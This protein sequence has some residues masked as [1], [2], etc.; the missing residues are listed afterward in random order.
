MPAPPRFVAPMQTR[1]PAAGRAPGKP[2]L[3]A[4]SNADVH[5]M[6]PPVQYCRRW[7]PCCLVALVTASAFGQDQPA[8]E[9]TVGMEGLYYLRTRGPALVARPVD[10]KAPVVLRI[11]DVAQD[12]GSAIYELRYAGMVPGVHDL[13]D[14]LERV[15][16]Q[17]LT[18]LEPILVAVHKALPDN[19]DG[20]LV[21]LAVPG[22]ARAWMYRLGLAAVGVLWL[23]PMAWIVVKRLA[24]RRSAPKPMRAA[25]ET[26]ADQLQPLIEAAVAGQLT[27]EDQARLELLLIAYWRE[28][29]DLSGCSALEALARMRGHPDCGALLAQLERWLH[30][31]PGRHRVDVGAILLPYRDHPAVAGDAAMAQEARP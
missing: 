19:H 14:F 12:G 16:G 9:T 25:E 11:A 24:R 6:S 31:P 2:R 15:D 20:Q 27:T 1:P 23:L 26:L 30:E 5:R 10:D 17:R 28:Q 29:L 18:G 21:E 13:R 4:M 22:L 8:L 3:A 7:L